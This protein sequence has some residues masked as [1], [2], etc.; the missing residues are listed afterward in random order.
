MRTPRVSDWADFCAAG[1]DPKDITCLNAT[2][3]ALSR[4]IICRGS[5]TVLSRSG[6]V[7]VVQHSLRSR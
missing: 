3:K 5:N 1:L 2:E 6:S 7:P 4:G